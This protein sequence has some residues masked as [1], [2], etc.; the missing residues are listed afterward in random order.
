M[1]RR[2][3]PALAGDTRTV[4][5]RTEFDVITRP[6]PVE[7]TTATQLLPENNVMKLFESSAKYFIA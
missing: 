4:Y 1:K 6:Q 3:A 5:E 2:L 7:L